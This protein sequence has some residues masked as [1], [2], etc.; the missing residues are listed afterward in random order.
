MGK[1]KMNS[2]QKEKGIRKE[3][4]FTKRMRNGLAYVEDEITPFTGVF[5]FRYGNGVVK[6]Y[7]PFV[8]GLKEG[9][10]ERFYENGSIKESNT[11]I[12]GSLNGDSFIFPF[13]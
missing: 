1:K 12:N 11:F 7:E 3:E 13:S 4:F 6:E 8:E 10:N 5:V 2:E 9:I